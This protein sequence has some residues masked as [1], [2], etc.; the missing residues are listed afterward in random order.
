MA[1]D[2]SI[3][4]LDQLLKQRE[5]R[6]IISFIMML[7]MVPQ[8]FDRESFEPFVYFIG[9]LEMLSTSYMPDYQRLANIGTTVNLCYLDG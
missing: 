4:M 6:L 2:E 9:Y 3:Q 7:D 8:F 5:G 1:L